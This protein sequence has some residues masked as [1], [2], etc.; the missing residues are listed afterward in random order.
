[1]KSADHNFFDR[2]DKQCEIQPVP[3]EDIS[4]QA[5]GEPSENIRVRVI[6]ARKIQEE[7]YRNHPL[8]HCNAQMTDRM[9]HEFC[10]PTD[11]RKRIE[12][13]TELSIVS[14]LKVSF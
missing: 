3:F 10:T 7:R 6:K 2:I 12:E 8:I 1:M 4:K 9:L 13:Q 5:E 14:K 11:T